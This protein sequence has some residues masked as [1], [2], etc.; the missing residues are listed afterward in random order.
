VSPIISHEAKSFEK[1]AKLGEDI[2]FFSQNSEKANIMQK[3]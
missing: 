1:D 2:S 3:I